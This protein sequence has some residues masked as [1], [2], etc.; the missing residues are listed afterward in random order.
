MKNQTKKIKISRNF[1]SVKMVWEDMNLAN[2][3]YNRIKGVN[4]SSNH[5]QIIYTSSCPMAKC[6]GTSLFDNTIFNFHARTHFWVVYWG[7]N[8]KMEWSKGDKITIS[9]NILAVKVDSLRIEGIPCRPK[10]ATVFSNYDFKVVLIN[11][12]VKTCHM[13]CKTIISHATYKKLVSYC[14]CTPT[15]WNLL[16]PKLESRIDLEKSK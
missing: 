15:Y 10:I 16:R 3:A 4:F 13:C 6:P 8:Q 11:M 2:D 9:R 5:T 14:I 12:I 7:S 1:L